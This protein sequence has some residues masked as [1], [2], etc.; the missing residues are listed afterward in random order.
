VRFHRNLPGLPH[1][2]LEACLKSDFE[3]HFAATENASAEAASCVPSR[4]HLL[5]YND[6]S[7]LVVNVWSVGLTSFFFA[8]ASVLGDLSLGL[9]FT[10]DLPLDLAALPAESV[11]DLPGVPVTLGLPLETGPETAVAELP[12][13]LGAGVDV[14]E[15]LLE[16]DPFASLLEPAADEELDEPVLED[17]TDEG[18]ELWL[19]EL[20]VELDWLPLGLES[21]LGLACWE[22]LCELD[23]EALWEALCEALG[24]ALWDPLWE[25]PGELPWELL[26]GGVCCAGGGELPAKDGVLPPLS[27]CGKF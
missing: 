20:P 13:P 17:P 5:M 27:P 1:Q 14:F 19:L 3:F 9:S 12:L 6:W 18:V 21:E 11:V 15:L 25:A 8:L 23:C 16:E 7:S 2:Q 4:F 22:L 10:S 24:E 26:G